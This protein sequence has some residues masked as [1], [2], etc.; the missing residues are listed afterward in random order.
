MMFHISHNFPDVG[1]VARSATNIYDTLRN[2]GSLTRAWT[3]VCQDSTK[4][5]QLALFRAMKKERKALI[6][7]WP[8]KIQLGANASWLASIGITASC[9]VRLAIF[10]YI[11]Y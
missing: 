10:L 5:Q 8:P 9:I 7:V 11:M 2:P 3:S 4:M 1:K 6:R